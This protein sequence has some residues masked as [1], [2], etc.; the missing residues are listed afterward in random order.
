MRVSREGQQ[1]R[2]N[3]VGRHGGRN[4]WTRSRARHRGP[5][6]VERTARRSQYAAIRFAVAATLIAMVVWTTPNFEQRV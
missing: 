6:V 4:G 3:F 5:G 2:G 1:H